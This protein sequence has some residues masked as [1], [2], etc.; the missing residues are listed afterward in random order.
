MV[1]S[2]SNLHTGER[3]QQ[4]SVAK[5]EAPRCQTNLEARRKLYFAS[6]LLLAQGRHRV[7]PRNPA[8]GK[9]RGP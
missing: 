8:C 5:G 2:L 3:Y 9:I 6:P 1:L 7:E 4:I